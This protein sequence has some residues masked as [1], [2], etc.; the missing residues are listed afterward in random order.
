MRAASQNCRASVLFSFAPTQRY[1]TGIARMAADFCRMTIGDVE[2]V[3]RLHMAVHEL[4]EN[5]GKYGAGPTAGVEV[6]LLNRDDQ[7]IVRLCTRN[8]SDA[9]RLQRAV[10]LLTEL[11]DAE[12]PVAYYDRLVIESAPRDDQSGLGLARIRAEAELDLD[13]A[14]QGSELSIIAEA[15]LPEEA[16]PCRP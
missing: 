3:A 5:V 9:A 8:T 14:V 4:V 10:Q 2:L 7:T 6:Q 1:A 11:R 13:F 12:D 15:K 16:A